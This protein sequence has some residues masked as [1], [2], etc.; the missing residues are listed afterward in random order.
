MKNDAK[1]MIEKDIP[2][3]GG[4]SI[5]RGST[6]YRTHGCLYLDGGLLPA[7]YAEDFEHLIDNE[8]KNGWKYIVPIKTIE[9]NSII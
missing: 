3:M 2:L 4:K 9:G 5:K 6:L 7:D 8:Q 1:F